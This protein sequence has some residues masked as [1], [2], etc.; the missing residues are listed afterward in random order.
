MKYK[1]CLHTIEEPF[2]AV[3]ESRNI[4]RAIALTTDKTFNGVKSHMIIRPLCNRK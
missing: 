4:V 2:H 1:T 3:R